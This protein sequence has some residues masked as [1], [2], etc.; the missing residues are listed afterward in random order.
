M[1][2]AMGK[3]IH[4]VSMDVEV[5]TVIKKNLFVFGLIIFLFLLVESDGWNV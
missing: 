4:V 1:S 3:D 5:I 2:T